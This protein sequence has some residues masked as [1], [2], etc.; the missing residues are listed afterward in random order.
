[1]NFKDYEVDRP[2]LS[3]Y[4][5]EEIVTRNGK[6]VRRDFVPDLDA[7]NKAM[8]EYNKKKTE[9]MRNFKDDLFLELGIVNHPKREILYDIVCSHSQSERLSSIFYRA[10]DLVRLIR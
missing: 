6:V 5:I 2:S 10:Y 1:M 4:N 8:I 3:N 7:F 9:M